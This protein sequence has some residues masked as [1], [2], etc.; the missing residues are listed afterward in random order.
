MTTKWNL[1]N[2]D[3]VPSPDKFNTA[4]EREGKLLT[5]PFLTTIS[6]SSQVEKAKGRM[7]SDNALAPVE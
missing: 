7:C 3:F 1:I 4:E 2:L 5:P 6:L